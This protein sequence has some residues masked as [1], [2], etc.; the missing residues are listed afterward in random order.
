M[1]AS[2][3]GRSGWRRAFRR[4]LLFSSKNWRQSSYSCSSLRSLTWCPWRSFGSRWWTKCRVQGS[5]SW[6]SLCWSSIGPILA[7]WHR[8]KKAYTTQQI[9][10]Q[11][12]KTINPTHND[13][14]SLI[15]QAKWPMNGNM[16]KLH[17]ILKKYTNDDDNKKQKRQMSKNLKLNKILYFT[18]TS[19]SLY[20][21]YKCIKTYLT[22]ST[23]TN[24]VPFDVNYSDHEE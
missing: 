21:T 6:S 10:W 5:Q 17:E 8:I 15:T 14:S 4:F 23:A 19:V 16:Q 18:S 12:N 3:W 22:I 9:S 24:K 13:I 2:S 1:R 7:L 11:G 20:P